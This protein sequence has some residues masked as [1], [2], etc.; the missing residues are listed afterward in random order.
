[1][2]TFIPS[3]TLCKQLARTFSL[4]LLLVGIGT[5][6][7]NAQALAISNQNNQ[8][9]QVDALTGTTTV[10]ASL[11]PNP[12]GFLQAGLCLDGTF[13]ALDTTNDGELFTIAMDGTVTSLGNMTTN[14]GESWVGM[15]RD[16]ATGTVYAVSGGGAS[17][18]LYTVDLATATAT[19]VG[20]MP[21]IGLAIWIVIDGTG[22][23]VCDIITDNVFPVNLADGSTGPGVPFTVDGN[24][25]DINFGQDMDFDGNTITG[26]T[27]GYVVGST[28]AYGRLDPATGAFTTIV[29]GTPQITGFSFCEDSNC[30]ISNLPLVPTM[31]EWGLFLFMM[32]MMTMSLVFMYNM[33]T[34]QNLALAGGVSGNIS[35]RQTMP[36]DKGTFMS[37]IQPALILSVV[38]FAVIL[39]FWG[40]IV[41]LDIIGMAIAL[42]LAAYNIHLAKMFPTKK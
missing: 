20:P 32:V 35:M 10:L 40:E 4:L 13:Y 29:G 11:N 8:L 7:I 14:G 3:L 2:K 17:S 39:V 23:Y 9:L 15:D 27:Y 25:T 34:Q 33:Q 6:N 12:P 37:A 21:G 1:M 38:G 24:P 28:N 16:A 18:S 5:S 22:A 31:S 41:A 42:P 19:L 36:F 26:E 30:I